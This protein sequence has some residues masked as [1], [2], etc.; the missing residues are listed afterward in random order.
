MTS[1][2]LEPKGTT[3]ARAAIALAVAKQH[4]ED[5]ALYAST[6]WGA[7]ANVADTIR[8]V[9]GST[10]GWGG[11]LA[12]GSRAATEFFALVAQST[13]T[14]RLSGL[15]RVPFNTRLVSVASGIG[16]AWVPEG[17]SIPIRSAEFSVAEIDR[18]KVSTIAVVT[19]DLLKSS[20]PAAEAVIR[21]DLIRAVR[22]EIDTTFLALDNAGEPGERPASVTNGVVPV[23]LTADMDADIKAL[24]SD[25]EGDLGAAYLIA[26]PAFATALAGPSRPEAGARG[27]AVSGIPL[28]TSQSAPENA[29]ILIDPTRIAIAE[30]GGEIATTREATVEMLDE[31]A[32]GGATKQVSLWQTNS[33]GIGVLRYANWHALPGSVSVLGGA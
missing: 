33:A 28:V 31:D 29:L 27:G 4:P 9:S 25:F 30:E 8:A 21:N 10:S 2:R 5:A 7:G 24:I 12:A 6:R 11:E 22:E 15:R 32:G 14:G 19:D 16:A 23:P 3:F 1:I 13:V 20:D 17:E 26:H 18:L